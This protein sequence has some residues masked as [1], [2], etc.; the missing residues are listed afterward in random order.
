MFMMDECIGHMTEKV[1]IPDVDE[2]YIEPRRYTDK[3]PGEFKLYE[4]CDDMVPEMP[5]LG[6]GYSFHVTGLTHDE[7]GYPAMNSESQR[8]LV[9]RLIHKIREFRD[10]IILYDA[11]GMDDAEVVVISYGITSRIS[12][13]AVNDARRIGLKIGNL[14]LKTLWPFPTELVNYIST[15]VKTIV[16]PELNAGQMV[17]EVQRAV[18]GN[19]DVISIPHYGG[20]VH[21]VKDILNT[22]KGVCYQAGGSVL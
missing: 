22:I 3:S 19:C 10:E 5:V 17:L 2:L 14:K 15:Y 4:P 20:G 9:S 11:D 7:R 21:N 12:E 13:K 18:Q 16:V 6:A 1:V 8:E